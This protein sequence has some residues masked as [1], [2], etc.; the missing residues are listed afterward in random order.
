MQR[1][2]F[3]SGAVFFTGDAIAVSLLGYVR[4]VIV[5]RRSE[6]ITVPVSAS[7]GGLGAVTLLLTQASQISAESIEL[8]CPE[9]LDESFVERVD[10]LTTELLTP[11]MWVGASLEPDQLPA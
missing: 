7:T 5:M 10:A 2:H 8:G 11:A 9:L 1:V 3:C 6:A 4:A